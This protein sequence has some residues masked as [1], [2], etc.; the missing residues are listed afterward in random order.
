MYAYHTHQMILETT[1]ETSVNMHCS[2]KIKGIIFNQCLAS[3][4]SNVYPR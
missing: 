4:H 1:Q 3:H 2:K